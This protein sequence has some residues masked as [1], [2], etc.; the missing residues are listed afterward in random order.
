M[1]SIKGEDITWDELDINYRLYFFKQC[2]KNYGENITLNE[3]RKL[4][5]DEC[6]PQK[7]RYCDDI[8][9]ELY[10]DVKHS[11]ELWKYYTHLKNK[12]N[13]ILYM[14]RRPNDSMNFIK[15]KKYPSIY[16]SGRVIEDKD[17]LK[18]IITRL[19]NQYEQLISAIPNSFL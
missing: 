5:N 17:Q 6:G 13:S 7:L 14:I 12:A 3:I 15:H 2:R 11:E 16:C 10:N 9:R 4:W 8:D 18:R 19:R 1:C